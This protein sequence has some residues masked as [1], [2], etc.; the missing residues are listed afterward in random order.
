[1][2]SEQYY[3]SISHSAYRL[4]QRTKLQYSSVTRSFET[5]V[6]KQYKRQHKPYLLHLLSVSLHW[7][8]GKYI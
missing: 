7:E 2:I 5:K 1:M 3:L 4:Q 6:N 8:N